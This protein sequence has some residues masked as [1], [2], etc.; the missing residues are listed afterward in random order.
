MAAPGTYVLDVTLSVNGVEDRFEH[1]V[2]TPND[3]VGANPA[4]RMWMMRHPEFPVHSYVPPT[5]NETRTSLPLLT[6]RQFRLGLVNND[7]TLVQVAAA[8]ERMQESTAKEV[9][10]IEWEYGTTFNRMHPLIAIV[11]AALGL[12]DEQVDEMWLA[13]VDL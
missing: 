3:S 10:K 4:I 13:C 9:A 8:I 1:Y 7:F 11:T 5:A 12:S 2:S 6:S